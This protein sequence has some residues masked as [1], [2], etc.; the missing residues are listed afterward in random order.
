MKKLLIV[1]I[2]FLGVLV[3]QGLLFLVPIASL[4]ASAA[5]LQN[6]AKVFQTNCAMCHRGGKNIIAADKTLD[7]AA[8]EK[9]GKDSVEAIAA[10]VKAGMNAMPAFKEKLSETQ[11]EDVAAYVLEQA[12]I[13]WQ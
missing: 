1:A 5:D 4:P 8:L 11:I 13:G 12:Q 7:K 2:L 3:F 9:Y 10:Q 6:G